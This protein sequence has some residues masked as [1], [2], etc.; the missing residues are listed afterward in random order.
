MCPLSSSIGEAGAQVVDE[1]HVVD[2]K[3]A[4]VL[5]DSI[6]GIEAIT[7]DDKTGKGALFARPLPSP[8]EPSQAEI[9]RHN[10]THLPYACW[11]PICVASRR[12]NDHHRV[13]KYA[14]RT[15]PLLVSEYCF[16]KKHK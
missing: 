10:L 8:K 13:Q 15:I 5:G 3:N 14:S 6:V 12:P 9:D 2:L 16:V 7:Y 4:A 1:D 11:C